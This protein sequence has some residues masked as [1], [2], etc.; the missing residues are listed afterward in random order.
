MNK[1]VPTLARGSTINI[2]VDDFEP[3]AGIPQRMAPG[4]IEEISEASG[5]PSRQARKPVA[6]TSL[7]SSA[8]QPE[9]ETPTARAGR[10]VTKG[11]SEVIN[12]KI[13]KDVKTRFYAIAEE[14]GVSLADVFDVALEALDR[15]FSAGGHKIKFGLV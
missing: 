15:E 2:D 3:K 12:M 11:R 5:F 14:Q 7:T 9:I 10:R 13:S 6:A 4:V 8:K 1:T